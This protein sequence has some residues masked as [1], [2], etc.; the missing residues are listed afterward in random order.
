MALAFTTSTSRRYDGF[1][2]MR[3]PHE[4]DGEATRVANIKELKEELK[5]KSQRDRAYIIVLQG[6]N[7]GEMHEIGGQ[8][9]V[10][11]R[12]QTAS[13]RL[14]DE[15]V[16]RKHAQITRS[17]DKFII[18]DLNSSNG[19]LVNGHSVQQRILEDG[20]KISLGQITVLKFTYHD[21]LDV[22]FQ[23]Q[24]LDA[25]LRD[26]LTKA[27]N[28]RYFLGRIETELAYARR[29]TS[30]LSLVM[31]DV[32]HFKRVNDT[33]GHLAGD[34][35]LMKI[36]KVTQNT[37]RTEDVF[38]RYGGEEFAVLCRGVNLNNAGILG[39]RLR[40]AMELSVFEHEGTR[41]P[42]TISVG[43]AA[44]PELQVET[45]EQLIGAA[46]EALYQAKRTGRNRVLLKH[47]T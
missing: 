12:G 7:V 45:P 18:E 5:A 44:F 11:G 36:S 8:E 27:F 17:G 33:Y 6:S 2:T 41:M 47:G 3:G 24:M 20:D 42:I 10:L 4:D 13:V 37:V 46:D 30:A 38:A 1:G 19:T 9:M 26:G 34:Y 29:H 35:V 39:E 14:N 15:G 28:K 23:Q 40:S 32:D 43:V 21:H 22:S 31:F 16:S 25:A